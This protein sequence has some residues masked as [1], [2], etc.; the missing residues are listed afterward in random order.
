MAERSL[1][2]IGSGERDAKIYGRQE[3]EEVEEKE[4]RMTG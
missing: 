2:I 1:W 3:Q 4:L